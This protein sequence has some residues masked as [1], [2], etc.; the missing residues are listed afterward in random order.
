MSQYLVFRELGWTWRFKDGNA[1]GEIRGPGDDDW[2]PSLTHPGSF[3]EHK[4]GAESPS[5]EDGFTVG[6][7]EME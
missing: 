4:D 1:P 6:I 2:V 7:E 3:F 5:L